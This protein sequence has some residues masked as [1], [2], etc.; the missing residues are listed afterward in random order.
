MK[1]DALP[2]LKISL[3]SNGSNLPEY[4]ED[5]EEDIPLPGSCFVEITAEATFSVHVDA[6][7]VVG[8]DR[9]DAIGVFVHLDG[10][11]Q[12]IIG[13]ICDPG[14]CHTGHHRVVDI[15]G[16]QSNTKG[17]S[18]FQ[19]FQFSALDTRK[20]PK[21]SMVCLLTPGR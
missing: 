18:V 14:T 21:L 3:R 7:K 10:S 1:V 20:W 2:G 6:R 17:G 11:K 12:S 15:E 5:I 8:K 13:K 16:V 9:R 19:K 4:E